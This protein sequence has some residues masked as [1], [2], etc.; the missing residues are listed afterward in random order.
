MS[1]AVPVPRKVDR[2]RTKALGGPTEQVDKNALIISPNEVRD[3]DPFL[4][5]AEDWFSSPG[6]EWHPHRG[7]ETVTVVLDGKLEHGDSLGHAGALEPGDIQWMTAGKGIIHRELAYHNEFAHTLQLWLNLP[8]DKRM[9]DTRYQD[10]RKP[11]QAVVESPGVLVRVVSGTQSGITGTAE[12]QWPITGLLVTLEPGS[13]YTPVLAPEDRAFVYV[14]EGGATVAGTAVADGQIAWSDPVGGSDP[15]S[16]ELLATDPDRPT[17][18]MLFS[19]QPIREPIVFGGPFVMGSRAEI[20][21]A[22]LDFRGGKF[23]QIPR[24]ARL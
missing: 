16:I 9:V 5:M 12:N 18:L 24:L 4:L 17:T 8:G 2:V 21:Q 11:D 10:L 22:Y 23:G 6:F 19:G 13:S 3:N 1:A 7:V 14:V 20:E 15:T